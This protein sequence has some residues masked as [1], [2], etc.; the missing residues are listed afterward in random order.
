M[1]AAKEVI[2][3]GQIEVRF[4]LDSDDT[5]GANTMFE[6]LVGP[7]AKVPAPHYHEGFDELI[8]GLEGVLTFTVDGVPGQIGPGDSFFVPRGVVHHFENL[9]SVTTRSLTVITPGLLG[10]AYFRE[11]AALMGAGGPPDMAKVAEVM[12]AHGLFATP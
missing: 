1:S 7:G 3:L 2:K 8:Y 6:F 11:I 12:R 10:P 9:G 5:G 4:L